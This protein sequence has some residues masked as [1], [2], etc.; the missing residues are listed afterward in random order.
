MPIDWLALLL[1]AVVLVAVGILAGLGGRMAAR[2]FV[3][4]TKDR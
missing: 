2:L 3:H 1:W 4:A